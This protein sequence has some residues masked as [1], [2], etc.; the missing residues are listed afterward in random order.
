MLYR[1]AFERA[2]LLKMLL[3][4][5]AAMLL[6]ICLL[7]LVETTN[8][9]EADDSLPE[10]G[11][12]AFTSYNDTGTSADIYVMN[13]D[14]TH[15]ERITNIGDRAALAP[16]WSPDG[17]TIAFVIARR[18][19]EMNISVLSAD[20]TK[21]AFSMQKQIGSTYT[22]EDI[23]VINADGSGQ[24][25]LTRTNTESER[26]PDWSPDGTRIAFERGWNEDVDIYTMNADGS[27][28]AQLTHSHAPDI[29]PDWQ[30]QPRPTHEKS[31]S[32]TVRPP[33]TG[34]PSLLLVGGALLF[35]VGVLLYAVVRR[36]M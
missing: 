2:N 5:T 30:P 35:A 20:G 29:E 4:S 13:A 33:D 11:K 23:Y 36:R 27:D 19:S 31:R 8:T 18:N 22:E 32:E 10:N 7:A 34:G 1:V 17:K 28:V 24:T 25:N 21:I 6:A 26:E 15:Q 14:G 3:V 12:I 9:A 16:A